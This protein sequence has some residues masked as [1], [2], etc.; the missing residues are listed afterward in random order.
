MTKHIDS[1]SSNDRYSVTRGQLISI[2][3]STIVSTF[4]DELKNIEEINKPPP[5]TEYQCRQ[6]KLPQLKYEV[7]TRS[8]M[9]VGTGQGGA[10]KKIDYID[11]LLGRQ[12]TRKVVRSLGKKQ[13]E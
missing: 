8:L 13:R 7:H 5:F 9:V 3:Q 6:M 11:A 4:N 10:A 2:L 12:K 1:L